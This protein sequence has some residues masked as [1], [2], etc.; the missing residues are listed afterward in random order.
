[1]VSRAQ[2]AKLNLAT[3]TS[4]RVVACHEQTLQ[5]D[6]AM[7]EFCDVAGYEDLFL[8]IHLPAEPGWASNS[9][10]LAHDALQG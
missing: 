5:G 3:E 8:H 7:P 9:V 6:D 10:S 1:M 2:I 4:V